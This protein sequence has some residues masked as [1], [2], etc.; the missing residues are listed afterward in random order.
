VC[1]VMLW[2]LSAATGC[3]SRA[4]QLVATEWPR[5]PWKGP[6]GSA[7]RLDRNRLRSATLRNATGPRRAQRERSEL[8]CPCGRPEYLSGEGPCKRLHPH[9]KR[10]HRV[11]HHNLSPKRNWY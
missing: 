10:L 5:A 3:E 11:L 9:C 4:S 6:R 7:C 2:R 8:L 1:G